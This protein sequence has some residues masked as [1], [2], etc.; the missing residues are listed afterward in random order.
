MT[1]IKLIECPRDAMQGIHHFI[2]TSLKAEYINLLLQVGFD[3]IDFGSFVSAKAIPQLKDTAE[4]LS[5]LD[6]SSSK[7]KLLAIVAN[8]RGAE[9]A[10]LQEEISYLGFP[11]SLSETFQRRNTNSSMEE[12][13]ET[14]ERML[15]LCSISGKEAV[16]YLSMGFG[17]P[18]GDPWDESIVAYWSSR[19]VQAGASIISLSDTIGVST[20]D[21]I[22]LLLKPLLSDFSEVEIGVHLHSTPD[23]RLEKLEAAYGAGCRRFDSALKGYGGCPMA[24]DE[25]TGN[26]DTEELMVFLE[27]KGE[28]LNLDMSKWNEAMVLS[29]RI[30]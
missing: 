15:E 13:M 8:I 11:F 4:V 2:D 28:L 10:I 5:L 25:L 1:P 26:M 18:Y 3:T 7:S 23:T 9:E 16:I 19:L 20:P 14:V 29:Q 30:F 27:G 6:M 24:S 17:N 12:S 21:K 22:D